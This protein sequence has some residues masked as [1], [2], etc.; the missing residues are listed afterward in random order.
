MVNYLYSWEPQPPACCVGNGQRADGYIAG[1]H[2]HPHA[3]DNEWWMEGYLAGN[4]DH[5]LLWEI[6]GERMATSP[7]TSTPRHLANWCMDVM[8]LWRLW[9]NQLV[10]MDLMCLLDHL[11]FCYFGACILCMWIQTCMFWTI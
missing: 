6:G 2:G 1:N 11:L 5:D 7:G 4:Q 3:T 9:T 8:T 10:I